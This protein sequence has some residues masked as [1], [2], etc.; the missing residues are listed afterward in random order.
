ML[1]K[2]A[3]ADPSVGDLGDEAADPKIAATA[4]EGGSAR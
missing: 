4:L 2:G 1:S 3:A